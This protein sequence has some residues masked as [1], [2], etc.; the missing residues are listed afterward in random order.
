MFKEIFVQNAYNIQNTFNQ[1]LWQHLENFSKHQSNFE[2]SKNL[3]IA[4]SIEKIIPEFF[5]DTFWFMFHFWAGKQKFWSRF[6]YTKNASFSE[7]T[8]LSRLFHHARNDSINS[9]LSLFG[10]CF[11]LAPTFCLLG[12]QTLKSQIP[13]REAPV[14]NLSIFT[15]QVNGFSLM[16]TIN[17]SILWLERCNESS[18]S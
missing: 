11:L 14:I 1:L 16:L 5:S 9:L 10:R 4:C 6:E 15:H 7:H 3:E 17:A 13:F 12:N 2:H 8:V 18:N